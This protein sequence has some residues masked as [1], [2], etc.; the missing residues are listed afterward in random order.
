[1]HFYAAFWCTF[2]ALLT[3]KSAESCEYSAIVLTVDTPFYGRR[4]RELQSPLL[5]PDDFEIHNLTEAG[6]DLSTM[7]SAQ[8]AIYISSLLDPTITWEDITWLQSITCLPIILKGIINPEDA[9]LA[10]KYGIAGLIV[11]NHGGRQL[12]TVSATIEALPSIVKAVE[13]KVEVFIDGGIRRGTDILKALALGA[14]AVLVGRPVLWG[15][16]VNGEEGVSQVLELLREELSM[17]M[18]LCGCTTID[19]LPEA[20]LCSF[21]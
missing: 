9:L 13:N 21:P 8:R 2:T 10:I 20:G 17:A 16:A 1:V 11:S 12:D 15:L 3:I 18:A 19:Q 6:L 5:F 4:L 14:K 7:P